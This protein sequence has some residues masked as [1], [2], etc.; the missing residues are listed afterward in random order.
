MIFAGTQPC[1]HPSFSLRINDCTSDH[2]LEKID[3]QLSDLFQFRTHGEAKAL[4]DEKKRKGS[5]E[6]E[7]QTGDLTFLLDMLPDETRQNL[8]IPPRMTLKGKADIAG[9]Q[10][11]TNL[12]WQEASGKMRLIGNYDQKNASYRV[13]LNIDS[14]EPHHFLP[15]DSLYFVNADLR[16]EGEGAGTFRFSGDGFR[17]VSWMWRRRFRKPWPRNSQ[18]LSGPE[19][20]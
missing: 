12:L 3:I 15:K 16:A 6:L 7:A 14:L 13:H 1:D 20:R 4:L 17:N 9:P 11:R 5:L 19:H 10:Y 8:A 18:R 2:F